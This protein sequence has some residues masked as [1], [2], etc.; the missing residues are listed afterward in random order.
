LKISSDD[1]KKEHEPVI[2]LKRTND[3]SK[4][5]RKHPSVEKGTFRSLVAMCEE[6]IVDKTPKRN[7]F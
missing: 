4:G 6:A 5:H 2:F 1:P 7:T 3:F